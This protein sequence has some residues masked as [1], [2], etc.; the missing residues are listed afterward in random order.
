MQD[1]LCNWCL[2]S[3]VGAMQLLKVQ[4]SVG[5]S[6]PSHVLY[7]CKEQQVASV[8]PRQGLKL[9]CS[10]AEITGKQVTNVV[11]YF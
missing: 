3:A 10:K 11:L 8:R 2:G 9:L 7:L 4:S 6:Q 5:K 1:F